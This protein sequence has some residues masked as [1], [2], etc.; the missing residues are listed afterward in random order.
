MRSRYAA[1]ARGDDAYLM[2]SWHPD[3]RPSELEIDPE[4]VW[5]G[6]AILATS[7][8]GLLDTE[9]EVEFQARY[10]GS[11]GSG[12]MRERSRFV[13]HH[14]RWVYLSAVG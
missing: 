13:R 8:G 4:T 12:R 14:D 6:L 3:T 7:G 1:F 9:G 5:T 11:D 2:Y 10:R